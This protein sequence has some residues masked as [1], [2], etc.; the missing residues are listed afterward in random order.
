MLEKQSVGEDS[1]EAELD[2][3]SIHGKPDP[4]SINDGTKG[5]PANEVVYLLLVSAEKMEHICS[6]SIMQRLLC[7]DSCSIWL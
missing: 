7:L 5:Q 3:I 4:K 6:A 1:G 2:D